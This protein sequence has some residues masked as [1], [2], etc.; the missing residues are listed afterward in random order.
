MTQ[1]DLAQMERLL[2]LFVGLVFLTLVGLVVY[3]V[4]ASR[5]SQAKAA[6]EAHGA[7]AEL[8]YPGPA[9]RGVISLIPDQA[10]GSLQVDVEGTRYQRLADVEDPEVKRRIVAA[11]MELIR[12]TGVL[13]KSALEP[14]PLDKTRTWRENLRQESQEELERARSTSMQPRPPAPEEVE[15]HFLSLVA[16]L[17]RMP[18]QL[19]RPNL[20]DSIQQRLQPKP[21]DSDQPL[22]VVADIDA[23]LQR[24]LQL[25]PALQERGLRVRSGPAGKVLFVFDGQEYQGVD[26][27]PNLTA[28][29]LVKDAIREWDETT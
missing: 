29:Q 14:A 8:A 28:R 11:A 22:N 19:E 18:T 4:V 24:R 5:R 2:Y 7:E 9:A 17:S 3:V 13:G 25:M 23:I 27:V 12:F 10:G 16:E 26:E 6:L 1:L 21:L 15:K 20:V